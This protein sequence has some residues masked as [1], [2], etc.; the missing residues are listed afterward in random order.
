LAAVK[1]IQVVEHDVPSAAEKGASKRCTPPAAGIYQQV[2]CHF[3]VAV[4][5]KAKN[6]S[7]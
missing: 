2:T 3:S 1:A 4:V 5:K 6:I 7:A